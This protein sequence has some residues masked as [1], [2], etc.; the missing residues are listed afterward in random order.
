VWSAGS[1]EEAW[2]LI[3]GWETPP[4]LVLTDVSMPGTNGV[5]L[6]ERVRARYGSVSILAMSGFIAD[7]DLSERLDRLGVP[8]LRK[9]FTPDDLV[10]AVG[11]RL[12]TRLPGRIGR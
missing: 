8:V 3:T 7:E 11:D 4:D 10:A 1:A 5:E 9:P 6:S 12:T 2:T